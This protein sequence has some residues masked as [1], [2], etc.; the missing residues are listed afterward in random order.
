MG[1][2]PSEED[3][4]SAKLF[5]K[6]TPEEIEAELA[7]KEAAKDAK[8]K[9]GKKGKEKKEKKGKKGKGK[10]GKGKKGDDD[11]DP[12]WKMKTS[13]FYGDMMGEVSE[14]DTKWRHRDESHNFH[15]RHDAEIIK[16][17]KMIEVEDAVRI[18]VDEIMRE[19][20]ANLKAALDKDEGKKGKGKKG[21]KGKGKKGKKGKKSKDLTADRTPESLYQELIKQG[22]IKRPKDVRLDSMLGEYSYLGTTLQSMEKEGQPSVW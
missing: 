16:E 19:E 6:K 7:E 22:I 8:G 5:V 13:E 15:Q 4:G 12:G 17:Q 21:K 18:Q 2:Y 9:K 14:Y 20:L 11:E 3:G 10:K 1:D